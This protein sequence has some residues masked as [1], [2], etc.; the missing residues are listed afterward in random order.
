MVEQNKRGRE[1]QLNDKHTIMMVSNDNQPKVCCIPP[2]HL[3]DSVQTQ[4]QGRTI[5]NK[6]TKLR[7]A[8]AG[9][10]D[11]RKVNTR[12]GRKAGREMSR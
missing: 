3:R 1:A 2:T 9:G 12:Q 7:G 4:I 8:S 5:Q 10:K 6:T 11:S